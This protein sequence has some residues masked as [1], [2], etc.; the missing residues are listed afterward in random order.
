M[1]F[2]SERQAMS[3]QP[4]LSGT[5]ITLATKLDQVGEGAGFLFV[6][7]DL[8]FHLAEAKPAELDSRFQF[9]IEKP[10]QK[11]GGNP[12]LT[13]IYD[14]DDILLRSVGNGKYPRY[15][16]NYG[17][18]NYWEIIAS[19]HE[20]KSNYRGEGPGAMESMRIVAMDQ[21][22][23][24]GG[25]VLMDGMHT[26]ALVT[27]RSVAWL[28]AS[29]EYGIKSVGSPGLK[30][31]WFVV[32]EQGHVP[33]T[34]CATV[35]HVQPSS[36]GGGLPPLISNTPSGT[37][38]SLALTSTEKKELAWGGVVLAVLIIAAI[39]GYAY[40]KKK[41]ASK[42]NNLTMTSMSL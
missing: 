16:T 4:L 24:R 29:K 25:P 30:E 1:T 27:V 19:E 18:R 32:D 3:A 41:N 15:A 10:P 39:A 2:V 8:M 9:I 36:T 23:Q 42:A 12:D 21:G 37:V 38:S 7:R 34:H 35:Q 14:G 28:S 33:R 22:S 40:L 13:H 11:G 5:V 20:A 26:Y 6:D 31:S 17:G